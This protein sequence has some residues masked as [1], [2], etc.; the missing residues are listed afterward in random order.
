MGYIG[1]KPTAVPLTSA[2]IEDGVVSAAD[3][4]ANSV[5]SSELVDGSIDTSHIGAT[6]VTGAKLNNDVISAQTALGA[7]PADADELLVS[8]AG[9]LKRVDYSYLKGS[10]NLPTFSAVMN[11]HVTDIA[12]ATWT[13][14]IYNRELYD[15]GSL[16]NTSDGV[17]TCDATNAGKWLFCYTAQDAYGG[18]GV[19]TQRYF[20]FNYYNASE[21]EWCRINNVHE[22]T[23]SYHKSRGASQTVMLDIANGDKMLVQYQHNS[24]SS[25]GYL[26]GGSDWSGS[27][28]NIFGGMRLAQ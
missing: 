26:L 16:F 27:V 14:I 21:G 11:A 6:Q 28:A 12:S 19:S 23:G 17:F 20:T 4:G 24:G 13:T 10:N 25:D 7:T 18:T 15:T 2:D 1:N 3:L 5:D 22:L 8:D 9:V